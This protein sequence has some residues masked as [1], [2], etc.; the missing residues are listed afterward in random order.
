[1]NLPSDEPFEDFQKRIKESLDEQIDIFYRFWQLVYGDA[2]LDR[3]TGHEGEVTDLSF[4]KAGNMLASASLDGTVRRWRKGQDGRFEHIDPP[5]QGEQDRKVWSVSFSNNGDLIASGDDDGI[6]YLWN[7]ESGQLEQKFEPISELLYEE[8]FV[9]NV[10]FSSDDQ[11][12]ATANWDGNVKLWNLKTGDSF[13]EFKHGCKLDGVTFSPDGRQIA[14]TGDDG[15]VKVWNAANGDLELSIEDDDDLFTVE[16]HPNDREGLI[17]FSGK[18][19]IIKFANLKTKKVLDS[20]IQHSDSDSDVPV[21]AIAFSPNGQYLA[22][23]G[24]DRAIKLWDVSSKKQVGFFWCAAK[25]NSAIFN[26]AGDAIASS[27]GSNIELRSVS[28]YL[29][30]Y[31]NKTNQELFLDKGIELLYHL[32]PFESSPPWKTWVDSI[33]EIWKTK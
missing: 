2:E 26:P 3:L 19:G 4:N 24:K 14:S 29:D 8:R 33:S 25:V 11:V 21:Y 15:F 6:V 30:N 32:K 23:V 1:M 27:V 18:C 22:S 7:A 16:F 17:A 28:S 31:A 10:S 13:K 12:L 5:L 20:F 9:L